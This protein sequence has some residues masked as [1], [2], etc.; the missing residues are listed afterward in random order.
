MKRTAYLAVAFAA[1]MI[2]SAAASRVKA[3]TPSLPAWVAP[4]ACYLTPSV[5]GVEPVLEVQ[6]MWVKTQ[7]ATDGTE[8]WRNMAL[9]PWIWRQSDATCR[10][11]RR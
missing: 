1:G 4:G 6:G 3:D 9:A 7:V 11:T 8:Q 10:V 5:P 2:V